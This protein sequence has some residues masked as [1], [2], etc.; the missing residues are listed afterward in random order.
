MATNQSQVSGQIWTNERAEA[1]LGEPRGSVRHDAL[2]LG[3]PDDGA[4]V[5]LGGGAEDAVLH[6]LTLRGVAGDHHVPGL[7]TGHALPHALHHGS[8]LVAQHAGEEALGVVAVLGES[9]LT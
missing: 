7:D 3:G 1:C 9:D 8:G 5:G 2:A 6:V 4:Q